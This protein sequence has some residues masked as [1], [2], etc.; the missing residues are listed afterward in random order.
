MGA[1]P[2]PRSP[3]KVS[4]G[5]LDDNGLES[6]MM[7]SLFSMDG[8]LY[9]D[10]FRRMNP[11]GCGTMYF[12]TGLAVAARQIGLIAPCERK[13]GNK[14]QRCE[15]QSTRSTPLD[16]A[17]ITWGNASTRY[18][19]IEHSEDDGG[20]T[21]PRRVLKNLLAVAEKHSEN[22]FWPSKPED[23]APFADA[24]LAFAKEVRQFQYK[25]QPSGETYG[26]P[27][28]V[29]GNSYLVKHFTR[30]MLMLVMHYKPDEPAQMGVLEANQLIHGLDTLTLRR[31]LEWMPLQKTDGAK[32]CQ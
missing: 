11:P 17:V 1:A 23:L 4:L 18:E 7:N 10:M 19:V 16:P 2:P 21:P 30:S 31:I 8:C 25:A 3:R 24:I 14:R 27:G 32:G 13:T 9:E 5:D 22:L 26:F 12:S 29:S 6:M 20:S 28:G 15:S